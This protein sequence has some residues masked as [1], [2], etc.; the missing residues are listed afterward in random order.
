MFK[1]LCQF[2]L[3]DQKS[4]TLSHTKFWSQIGYLIMC[5]AFV[6]ITYYQVQVVDVL[7]WLVFGAVVIGNRTAIK[8]LNTI[9]NKKD[10]Q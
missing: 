3:I 2:L 8:A 6:H 10:E 1:F 7:V 4:K 5:W 9:T